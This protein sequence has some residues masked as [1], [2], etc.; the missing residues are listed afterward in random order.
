MGAFTSNFHAFHFD[1]KISR[2]EVA[3]I[4]VT[5]VTGPAR[6]KELFEYIVTYTNGYAVGPLDYCGVA[7]IIHGRYVPLALSCA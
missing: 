1:D 5:P 3:N 2:Q 6:T 7:R 4:D